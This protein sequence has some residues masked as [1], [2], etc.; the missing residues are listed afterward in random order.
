MEMICNATRPATAGHVQLLRRG[1]TRCADDPCAGVRT[2][3][4]RQAMSP[5]IVEQ[6]D[7]EAATLFARLN[8]V[9]R[10]LRIRYSIAAGT[11]IGALRNKRR[12]PWDDDGD[13]RVHPLDWSSLC[14]RGK[15]ASIPPELRSALTPLTRRTLR[16]W[17]KKH[18]GQG[19]EGNI[20]GM[21]WQW[22]KQIKEQAYAGQ[23]WLVVA[24]DTAVL[25]NTTAE[26]AFWI[27]VVHAG[28]ELGEPVR[29]PWQRKRF[30]V[31]M[32]PHIFVQDLSLF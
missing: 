16:H 28:A 13:V 18:P 29:A 3:G 20:G 15:S 26:P 8:D 11:L 4:H 21:H 30:R 23:Q 1:G 31:A 24:L 5:A 12:V 25:T 9:F 14:P 17:M 10:A 7:R 32:P 6:L 19:L 27:D 22:R 2:R